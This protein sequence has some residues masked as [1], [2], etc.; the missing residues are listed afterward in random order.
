LLFADDNP[1]VR[2]IVVK[3]MEPHCDVI[4]AT[5]GADALLKIID[6]P[7]RRQFSAITK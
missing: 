3:G 4:V 7:A 6:E 1:L 5:D 2:D